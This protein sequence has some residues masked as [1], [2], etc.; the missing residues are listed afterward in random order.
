MTIIGFA[1]T[2]V[3]ILGMCVLFDDNQGCPN[4]DCEVCRGYGC[5][6]CNDTGCRPEKDS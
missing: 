1:L 4:K 2:F 3:F 5:V 6:F